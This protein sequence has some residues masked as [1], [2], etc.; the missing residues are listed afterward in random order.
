M[1]GGQS[2]RPG[3]LEL[4]GRGIKFEAV[5]SWVW[6]YCVSHHL[7]SMGLEEGDLLQRRPSHWPGKSEG[8][9]LMAFLF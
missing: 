6:R 3:L 7:R 8:Q 4:F 5:Q 9:L 1:A 2:Y